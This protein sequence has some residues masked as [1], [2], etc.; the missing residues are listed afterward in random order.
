ML[1]KSEIL[2]VLRMPHGLRGTY[3]MWRVGI[4]PRYTVAR[5]T[6]ARHRQALANRYGI[7]ITVPPEKS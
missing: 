5:E 7:D 3:L 2:T 1:S 4:D 6:Y